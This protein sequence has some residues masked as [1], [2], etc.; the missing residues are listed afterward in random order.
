MPILLTT[1]EPYKAHIYKAKLE[2]EGISAEV[3]DENLVSVNWTLS[4]AVGGVK[5]MV[6]EADLD[7]AREVLGDLGESPTV[8]CPKCES[9]STRR[10]RHPWWMILISVLT[11]VPFLFGRPRW[12]CEDCNNEWKR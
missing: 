2:S 8:T 1:R 6:S 11:L 10:L 3:M 4:N 9:S 5:L 7:R 12:V